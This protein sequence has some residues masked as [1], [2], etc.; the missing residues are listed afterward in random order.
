M[1]RAL[2]F[3]YTR[4]IALG[5]FVTILAGSLLLSLPVGSFSVMLSKTLALYLENL[6]LFAS[7]MVPSGVVWMVLAGRAGVWAVLALAAGCVCAAAL[8]TLAAVS[9]THLAVYKRQAPVG[10][11]V[12]VRHRAQRHSPHRQPREKGA[13]RVDHRGRRGRYRRAAALRAPADPGGTDAHQRQRPA[14]AHL[15]EVSSCA[16]M[17]RFENIQF[18]IF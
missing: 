3:S 4:I 2:S 13:R 6:S 9:Y 15:F 5:F 10:R 7:G 11:P 1:K 16:R 18:V 12:P 17:H 14:A 8:P